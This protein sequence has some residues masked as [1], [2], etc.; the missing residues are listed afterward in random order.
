MFTRGLFLTATRI[1]SKRIPWYFVY[2][3]LNDFGLSSFECGNLFLRKSF[4]Y[5]NM[6]YSYLMSITNFM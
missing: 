5:N 6:H 4:G 3:S 1:L 2:L